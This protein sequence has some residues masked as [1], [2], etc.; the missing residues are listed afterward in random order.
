MVQEAFVDHHRQVGGETALALEFADDGEIVLTQPQP[1]VGREIF[2]VVMVDAVPP[3]DRLSYLA[4]DWQV[5]SKDLFC[6]H[7]VA[8]VVKNAPSATES[9]LRPVATAS[10]NNLSA[11]GILHNA[12][13]RGKLVN[14]G[15]NPG[16]CES[17]G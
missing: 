3:T 6:V 12:V 17:P 11:I 9:P 8:A 1:D 7:A 15:I 5:L 10:A 4:N 2:G 16:V 14:T 13:A